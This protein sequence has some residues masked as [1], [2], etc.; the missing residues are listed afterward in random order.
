MMKREVFNYGSEQDLPPQLPAWCRGIRNHRLSLIHIFHH[1]AKVGL[2][3]HHNSTLCKGDAEI[4]FNNRYLLDAL[5][6][7]RTEKVRMRC[8]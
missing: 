1:A 5:R 2:A 4:G 8:V 3:A 6:N 7:A